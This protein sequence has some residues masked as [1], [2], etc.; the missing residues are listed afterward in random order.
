MPIALS[1]FG[2]RRV[3]GYAAATALVATGV[4]VPMVVAGSASA[5]CLAGTQYSISHHHRQF[6]AVK[7]TKIT[8]NKPGTHTVE[9]IKAASLSPTYSASTAKEQKGILAA[10]KESYPK[11]R[12]TVAVTKGHKVTFSSRTGEH[13]TVRYGSRGDTVTWK[14]LDVTSTCHSTVL[15]TGTATFPRNNLDWLFAVAVE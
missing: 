11:V 9:I 14:K 7:G 3:A 8:F 6:V 5:A 1:S 2:T 4:A 13:V 15:K 12:G 10:M